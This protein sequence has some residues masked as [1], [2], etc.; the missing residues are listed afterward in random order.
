M[1][2][3][4]EFDIIEY[5][6]NNR[7]L[8][9]QT[10]EKWNWYNYTLKHLEIWKYL[11]DNK[12]IDSDFEDGLNSNLIRKNI[13]INKNKTILKLYFNNFLHKIKIHSQRY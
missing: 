6:K 5:R 1:S 7:I 8:N 12:V 11:L 4:E 2:F 3:P 13:P 10:I 9:T